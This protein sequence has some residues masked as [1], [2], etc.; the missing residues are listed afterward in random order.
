MPKL[1]KLILSKGKLR[2]I[3]ANTCRFESVFFGW[4]DT[5]IL[6]ILKPAVVLDFYIN[7]KQPMQF[8]IVHEQGCFYSTKIYFSP[9]CEKNNYSYLYNLSQQGYCQ[10]LLAE[11]LNFAFTAQR[12]SITFV[13]VNEIPFRF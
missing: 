1:N 5:T 4:Y 7:K 6:Q 11:S 2:V 3:V 13:F 12:E 10:L 8:L 9:H